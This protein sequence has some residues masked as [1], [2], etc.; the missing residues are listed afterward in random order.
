MSNSGAK[1]LMVVMN[2]VHHSVS[3]NRVETQ[4]RVTDK[5]TSILTLVLVPVQPSLVFREDAQ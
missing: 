1:R 2:F 3:I 4:K 5:L